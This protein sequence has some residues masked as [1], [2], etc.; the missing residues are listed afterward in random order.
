MGGGIQSTAAPWTGDGPPWPGAQTLDLGRGEAAVAAG[1]QRAEP[2]GTEGDALE[3]LDPVAD[4]LAHP[5]YLA[6]A[7]L[8]DREL[9][10]AP[11]DAADPGRRG[12]AVLELDP[13]AQPAQRRL[14]D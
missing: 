12:A 2:Q 14:A 6:L 10:L 7:P 13:V 9:E 4:R 1:R 8:V 11:A 3:R 5:P